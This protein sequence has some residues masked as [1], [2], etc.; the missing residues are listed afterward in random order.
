MPS[1]PAR[2]KSPLVII[3]LLQRSIEEHNGALPTRRHPRLP[4]YPCATPQRARPMRPHPTLVSSPPAP[5]Q[6]TSGLRCGLRSLYL[7]ITSLEPL[8]ILH[9]IP[10]NTSFRIFRIFAPPRYIG[11]YPDPRLEVSWLTYMVNIFSSRRTPDL[12]NPTSTPPPIPAGQPQNGQNAQRRI[13]RYQV[14]YLSR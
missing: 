2:V 3:F 10:L 7:P 14:R 9:R 4:T 12:W 6:R 1:R 8:P 11:R 13:E 5:R